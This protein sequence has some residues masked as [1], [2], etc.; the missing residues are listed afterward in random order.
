M[1][2]DEEYARRALRLL[3][4]ELDWPSLVDIDRALADGRRRERRHT[5]MRVG[6]ATVAVGLVAGGLAGTVVKPQAAPPSG[7]VSVE[8]SG[9][10]AVAEQAPP[11]PTSCAAHPLPVPPGYH[12]TI[13]MGG[14]PTGRYLVGSSIDAGGRYHP[15]L[16]TDG[17]P[18]M[19]D[20][21][22]TGFEVD[23]I[24]VN[25]SGAVAWSAGQAVFAYRDGKVSP[26]D[27]AKGYTVMHI[28]PV[29]DIYV[30]DGAGLKT[31]PGAA[32]QRLLSVPAAGSGSARE[33]QRVDTRQAVVLTVDDDGT[34]AG[35]TAVGSGPLSYGN[36]HATVWRDGTM[37]V[38]A[39]PY[40]GNAARPT[41]SADGWIGGLSW[42]VPSQAPSVAPNPAPTPIQ[43]Q[44]PDVSGIAVRWNLRTGTTEQL[45][46]IHDVKGINRYGWV[47]G[48]TRDG[49]PV[50]VLGDRV[51]TLPLP[52]G[53][54]PKGSIATTV[55]DDGRVIGG[56]AP[57]RDTVTAVRWT[58]D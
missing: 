49:R 51:V 37:T 36:S 23:G 11:A 46:G 20:P 48:V 41:A 25:A 43:D 6:A 22:G 45:P 3:D 30:T 21:A 28:D 27:A 15:L 50:A 54:E 5:A 17:A 58:C 18:R 24:A 4:E 55:S 53:A 32:P 14:D 39:P 56:E 44:T 9:I 10:A 38:L 35:L 52:P 26:V 8:P 12:S 16:W 34:A 1:E 40:A 33:L 13:V 2:Q 42:P 29:G 7:G 57:M 47:V 19:L 31:K